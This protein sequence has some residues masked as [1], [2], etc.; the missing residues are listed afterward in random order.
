MATSQD[1]SATAGTV[2]PVTVEWFGRNRLRITY[3]RNARILKQKRT[4]AAVV[5]QYVSGT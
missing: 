3:D 5:I 2:L 4:E 1:G